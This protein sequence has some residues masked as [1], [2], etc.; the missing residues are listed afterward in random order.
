MQIIERPIITEKSV[1]L[2]GTGTYTFAVSRQTTKSE[3]AKSIEN[4]YSVD[5]VDVRVSTV[6]GKTVR[7]KTGMGKENDWKKALVRLK[8]GQTL[9]AFDFETENKDKDAKEDKKP[10]KKTAD[11]E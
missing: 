6:K 8:K 1:A 11:K 10:A 9:K 3:I 2:A 5:V 4:L 7:R